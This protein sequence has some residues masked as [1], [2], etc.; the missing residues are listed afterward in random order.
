MVEAKSDLHLSAHDKDLMA[1]PVG[2]GVGR[3]RITAVLGRGGFGITYRAHDA[4]LNREVA[5]KEYLPSVFAVRHDGIAVLPSSTKSAEDFAV[6]RERFLEEGRILAGLQRTPAIVLVHDFLEANGTAYIVMEL[7]R[8]TTLEACLKAKGP[9]SSREVERILWP[10]LDGLERVH[11]TGFLHRDIKPANI[12]IGATGEPTLIDFGASRAA[13]V[14]RTTSLT[15]IF[16][17]GYAALEQ[18]T[19]ARQGPSTDIYG[20]AATLYHAITGQ[21]PPNAVERVVE[22]A[23]L[24]LAIR[25]LAGFSRD[26]LLGIDAGLAV[27]AGDRPQSIAAW[28]SILRGAVAAGGGDTVPWR[29]QTDA[30]AATEQRQEIETEK[31][32]EPEAKQR[33]AEP[34][35]KTVGQFEVS[36]ARRFE[37]L[38]PLLLVVFVILMSFWV[39]SIVPR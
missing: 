17:P 22:D 27:R 12:I 24:P 1:L 14:G 18:F 19:S 34:K 36:K 16:T 13:M 7:V 35:A 38:A 4:K 29:P 5:I 37:W 10:L 31:R 23:L 11:D 3:Y 32:L 8:G 21:K 28:R 6:G 20:L 9:L 30:D 33:A 39:A 15:A 25:R 26:L 2:T